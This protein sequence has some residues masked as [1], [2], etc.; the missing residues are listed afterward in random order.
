MQHHKIWFI[1]FILLRQINICILYF[2]AVDLVERVFAFC[3]LGVVCVCEHEHVKF[4]NEAHDRRSHD[5]AGQRNWR[6]LTSRQ[7][8]HLSDMLERKYINS[9]ARLD[10]AVDL[11][12]FRS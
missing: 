6:T 9:V 7:R 4:G 2:A 11:V 5:V 1:S 12:Q 10:G 8:A 3:V